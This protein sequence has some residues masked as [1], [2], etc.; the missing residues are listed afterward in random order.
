MYC[1][2]HSLQD[3]I[4]VFLTVAKS[5]YGISKTTGVR[6][7]ADKAGTETDLTVHDKTPRHGRAHQS[8][9]LS[10]Q[11]LVRVCHIGIWA[12]ERPSLAHLDSVEANFTRSRQDGACRR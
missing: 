11:A 7:S 10:M 1:R 2:V 5:D 4:A 8:K 9:N 12:L 6:Q 3:K